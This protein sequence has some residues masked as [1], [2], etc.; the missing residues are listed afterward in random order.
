MSRRPPRSTRTD[1]LFPYTTLFR[2][3]WQGVGG[4]VARILGLSVRERWAVAFITFLVVLFGAWQITLLPI[5]AVP[6]VTNRQVQIN[7]FVPTLGPV[8]MEKQV[9]LDRQSA[10]YGKKVSA[11]VDL[12]GRRHINKK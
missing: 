7:S 3:A 9:P 10:V 8:D 1:T 2:S 5:D 12:C 6:D 11:R 4:M